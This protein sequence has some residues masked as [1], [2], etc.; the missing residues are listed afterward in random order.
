MIPGSVT[1]SVAILGIV[2]S[3]SDVWAPETPQEADING[4]LCMQQRQQLN[5]LLLITM[6]APGIVLYC[7]GIA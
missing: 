7:S 4:Y 6:E 1:I 3:S 2:S 5:W